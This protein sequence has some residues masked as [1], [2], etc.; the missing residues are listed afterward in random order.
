MYFPSLSPS[1]LLLRL[2]TYRCRK[3]TLE[4]SAQHEAT[5]PPSKNQDAEASSVSIV[6][7]DELKLVITR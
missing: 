2:P 3:R 7:E 5:N 6:D 1:D 4:M